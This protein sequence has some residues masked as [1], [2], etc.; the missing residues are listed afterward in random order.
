MVLY[1]YHP[2]TGTQSHIL[3]NCMNRLLKSSV[4]CAS[5]LMLLGWASPVT[6]GPDPLYQNTSL[7]QFYDLPPAGGSPIPT[8]DATAFDNENEFDLFYNQS[9]L[10]FQL[11]K[12]R[13]TLFYTNN[14]TMSASENPVGSGFSFDYYPMPKLTDTEADTFYNGGF[15]YCS[16]STFPFQGFFFGVGQCSVWA[17]N[18]Y[19]PGVIDVGFDG[20]IK[21][22]GQ[23]L[24]LTSGIMMVEPNPLQTLDPVLGLTS[25]NISSIGLFGI[26][27]NGDWNP[28]IALT[29][30]S[31]AASRLAGNPS[32]V[33]LTLP[34][35][36]PY[37]DI[38][39]PTPTNMVSRSVFLEDSSFNNPPTVSVQPNVYIDPSVNTA[40]LGLAP[41][42]A[43]VEWIGQYQD[44]ASGA[45]KSN[46]LYLVDDY[47]AGASVTN[48]QLVGGNNTANSGLPSNYQFGTTL[49]KLNL[50]SPTTTSFIPFPTNTIVTNPYSYFNAQ[51]I[52]S[53]VPTN[54][55]GALTNLPGR[56]E[57]RSAREL[58]LDLAQIQGPNYMLLLCTN[59][60]DG[61][62]GAQITVPYSDLYLGVTNGSMS[63][64]N[65]LASQIPEW[66][67]TVQ[68]WS[69]RWLTTSSNVL[70]TVTNVPPPTL[71]TNVIIITNDYR[72]L[73]VASQLNPT[74]VPQVDNLWLH[75]TNDLAISDILNV[76]GSLFLDARS[77]TLT[78][79]GPGNG[80]NSVDG[81]LNWESI[82]TLGPTQMPNLLWF[83]NNGAFRAGGAVS[84]GSVIPCGAVINNGLIQ[85]QGLTIKTTNFLSNGGINNGNGSFVL[86]SKNT[87]LTNGYI[88]AGA[89][90]TIGTG[91]LL[92]S[93]LTLSAGKALNL[94]ATNELTDSDNTNGTFWSVGALA[95]SA[96][97]GIYLNNGFN[98]PVLPTNAAASDLRHTT[99]EN[100][101]NG[102]SINDL[103]AG[104]DRGA[105]VTGYTND[106]AIGHLILD[107]SNSFSFFRF[108]GSGV[109]NAIYV[110]KLELAGTAGNRDI[111]GDLSQLL[112]STNIV[113]YYADATIGGI[114]FAQ[115]LN[116]HNNNHLR[117]IPAYA[118]VF[119]ATNLVYPPGVTNSLNSALVHAAGLDSDGD[120]TANNAD[121]SP[122]F[123]PGQ[124]NFMMGVTN[125]PPPMSIRLQWYSIP[126]ATNV[127]QYRTNLM[128][129]TWFT[130]TNFVSP[131][132][133]PPPT[134][135][136]LTNVVYDV[137][138][139]VPRFYRVMVCP[140]T[141]TLYGP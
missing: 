112:I 134:G 45:I 98:A 128:S 91:N 99:V 52:A 47:L 6:A 120:G 92:T 37:F 76:F 140:N 81:E 33:P 105:S 39:T 85:D 126:A 83:T 93:N 48:L 41:G 4:W 117:W 35:S 22:K 82:T 58:N 38:E 42:A 30:I 78:T 59:Q 12:S 77:L 75:A 5:V 125:V 28:G 137:N 46:F 110:D 97:Q 86:T 104:V 141:T 67:G 69:T 24:D 127:V 66:S 101:A 109:S 56:L 50:G 138:P 136:P 131:A 90:I 68:G 84:L 40:A 71:V 64:S 17:T 114:S 73:L 23:G 14:G 7:S 121:S 26:D 18:V 111:N 20:I 25:P 54:L 57:I 13:D 15:I 113:L 9:S 74:T 34:F 29:P 116:H 88:V 55:I 103:W 135:W 31:A 10:G 16:S 122:I 123:V 130:L 51:L 49:T 53:S 60:Y 96:G 107:A 119:T 95:V 65:L 132:I 11:F 21:V 2:M 44:P 129:S 3:K 94:T 108:I 32:Q 79:N 63:F 19:N 70:I 72:V 62:E 139:P 100:F 89:S 80:A 36:V 87:V 43:I 1:F 102:V 115:L 124:I 61:A 118:G 27:T 106:L 8:I 133:T